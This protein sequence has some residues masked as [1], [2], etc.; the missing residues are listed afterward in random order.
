MDNSGN[1]WIGGYSD[2]TLGGHT[3]AGGH[4]A[5]VAEYDTN[6]NLLGTDFLATAADEL[7]FGLAVAPGGGVVVTGYTNGNLGGTNA[8]AGD[9]FVARIVPEP[10]TAVSLLLG[11]G[12][13]ASTTRANRKT[14]RLAQFKHVAN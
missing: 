6:G 1:L 9:I 8:G 10:T 14:G 7:L 2:S 5:F 13:L 4:D 11:L 3:N 12:V